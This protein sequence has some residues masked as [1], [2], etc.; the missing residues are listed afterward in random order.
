MPT[1]S[2]TRF[3]LWLTNP[4][5]LFGL[6]FL[7]IALLTRLGLALFNGAQ[8][9][10]MTLWPG[11]FIRGFGFDF[12][13]LTWLAAPILLY[14]ALLPKRMR[15]S[16]WHP[17]LR[18]AF[19]VLAVFLLLF[20][21]VAE[22]TFW[23]EFTSRF[24]FIAVDYLIYTN[25]VIGNIRES[26]PVGWILAAIGLIAALLIWLLRRPIRA[27]DAMQHSARRRA[28]YALLALVLPGLS[29]LFADIDQM[30]FSANAYANELSGN[31]LMTLAAAFVRNELDFD[32]FY[33]TMPDAQAAKILAELG[34]E[35]EPVQRALQPDANEAW[36]SV[37]MPFTKPARNIVLISVESLSAN[38]LGSFGNTKALTPRLDQLATDG[39][40]FTHLYATGTRTVRGLEALALGTPPIPGQAIVRRPDNGHLATVGELLRR[41]GYETLFL[42]GGYGYFD[43]MNVFFSGNDYRVVDRTAFPK[44]SIAFSN[45]WGVADESLFDNALTELDKV[46]AARKPFLA[47][48]MTTSNHRPYTYPQGRIDIPSP[49]G[50]DGA[51]KY[52]DY[53][54]GRFIDQ[55]KTKPWFKETLFVIVADHC[56]SA[57]GKTRLPVVGYHIPMIFYAPDLLKSG[58]VERVVSQLDVPPTLLETLGLPGDDHFFGQSVFEKNQMAPRAFISNYQELGYYK[59]D[60]LIVLG[61]KKRA[62]AFDIDPKTFEAKPTVM[63]SRLLDEAVAY[64]QSTF[65]AF[66]RGEMKLP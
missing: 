61:P 26:Y 1:T 37:R 15:I 53:A 14:E 47:Q 43:N 31:G 32:R 18:F 13:T 40:L 46:H 23:D 54:I 6:I 21:V 25:E 7:L 35:R 2:R 4:I 12:A 17:P 39:L 49:G 10:P 41:Q 34:V 44:G 62:D 56:A 30:R 3:S 63:D 8:T 59:N 45:I 52:T 38:Y 29:Y 27:A 19:F 24:N 64:Y 50:R 57:A 36:D 58:R 65:H 5:I 28:S 33:R 11:I 20:G 60:K 22:F 55:A 9:A 51:V 48:I 66:K 16:R 42:Y